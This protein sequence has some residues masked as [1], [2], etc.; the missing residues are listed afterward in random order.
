MVITVSQRTTIELPAN[1][2]LRSCTARYCLKVRAIAL[3]RHHELVPRPDSR[4]RFHISQ[5]F[6]ILVVLLHNRRR[7]EI[8]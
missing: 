4:A 5:G 2:G 7:D 8:A 6:S 1:A 3:R